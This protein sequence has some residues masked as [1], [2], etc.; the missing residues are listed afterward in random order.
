MAEGA[1]L[2]EVRDAGDAIAE[3]LAAVV[4]AGGEEQE[5]KRRSGS[6]VPR[7]CTPGW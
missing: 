3:A 4:A 2:I 6:A 7:G 5:E 1:L